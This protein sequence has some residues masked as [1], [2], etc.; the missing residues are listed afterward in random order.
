MEPPSLVGILTEL[1]FCNYYHWSG[2]ISSLI[3]SGTLAIRMGQMLGLD[4][5]RPNTIVS[6]RTKV[7]LE[8][9]VSQE[10]GCRA[11]LYSYILD[12]Y[13]RAIFN[14]PCFIDQPINPKMLSYFDMFGGKN[15]LYQ[16]HS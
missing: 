10:L 2:N 7:P 14:L 13:G 8:S 11:Y 6:V 15:S 4:E 12:F 5:M 3:F 9:T 16:Y 1:H